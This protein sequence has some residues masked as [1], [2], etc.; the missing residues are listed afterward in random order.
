[1][2]FETIL[3]ICLGI[4][5]A[6]A[7]GFRV[8]VP[9]FALSLASYFDIIPLNESWLWIGSIPALLSFGVAMILEIFGYYI[10][11]IDNLLDTIATPLAAIAGFVIMAST[12]LDIS[13][14]LTTILAIIAGSGSATAFQGLTTT[15]RL[16]SSVKTAGIGNPVVST[17]ETGTAFT[18]SSL[19]IFVPI[20]AV[21]IVILVLILIYW[22]YKNLK[23]SF[24]KI[25]AVIPARY[26]STRLPAKLMQ[27]LGGKSVIVRT[28]EAAVETQL[29]DDVFVVTDSEIIFNEIKSNNGKVIMSIKEHESGSDRIAE[30]VENLDVDIV[31]NVQG[32]EPFIDKESLEKL[33]EVFKNDHENKIDLAS[34]M[35]IIK[36]DESIS[37]PNNVKVVTDV[38]GFALYFSRA[39]IPFPRD[40]NSN[41]IYWKHIGVYA[42]RKTALLDFAKLPMQQLEATEKLEQLRYLEFGKRIKM[43]ETNHVGIGIDTIEDLEKARKMF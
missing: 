4:G 19:A 33:V 42:F 22:L 32:D 31:V 28:Y 9:V 34:L 29:F 36:D 12:L 13:P 37:N 17:A 39:F 26:N 5:L 3:S 16:A 14:M 18:L 15:T 7:S 27:D 38:Y 23:I 2:S 6:S 43:I 24:M 35:T 40:K 8:F 25:I 11:F 10:P 20:V 1:M 41:A 30:A 21:V